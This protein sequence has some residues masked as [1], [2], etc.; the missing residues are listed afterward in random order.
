MRHQV[1]H[2]SSNALDCQI[3]ARDC[4]ILL[5]TTS[6]TR[7]TVE[8][9]SSLPQGLVLMGI[10]LQDLGKGAAIPEGYTKIRCHFVY[11]CKHDG[12]FKSRFVAGGNM[13]DTP[14]DSIYS[15]VVSIPGI[16]L[17]TFIAELNGLELWATDIGN[18]YLE[19]VTKE[20]VA[21]VAGPEF[22]EYKGHTF[23]ILK[24]QY[25]LKSSGRRWHDRLHDAL[26]I[27]NKGHQTDSWDGN[28]SRID[29]VHWCVCHI[30]ARHKSR[31][32]PTIVFT[33][34]HEMASDLGVAFRDRKSVV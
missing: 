33:I 34:V 25:G 1:R 12:R 31:F 26:P 24:A 11:D 2:S 28:H 9:C 8:S 32:E 14:V 27:C 19:S 16:R 4:R 23:I 17:V 22:G 13:T 18:A 7:G 5:V 3:D 29:A 10:S 15:G 30:P 21:F 6:G 20:K